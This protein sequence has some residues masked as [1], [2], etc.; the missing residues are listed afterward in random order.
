MDTT[1]LKVP[2][3]ISVITEEDIRTSNA[4][5]ITDVL[6]TSTGLI[7]RDE[8]GNGKS[9][10]VDMRGF[11]ESSK[12]NHLV[13][14]D[15]RRINNIDLSATDWTQIPLD[16]VEKIEIARGA[17]SV[18]YGD[19][20]VAGV[21]NIITK[22]GEG[23]VKV[24]VSS[25]YGSYDKRL[26]KG[27]VS[28]S[29][30]KLSYSFN[31]SYS[32]SS[33]YRENNELETLDFA[34]RLHYDLD[35]FA[36][37]NVSGG[38]H[39]DSYGMPG[40]LLISDFATRTRRDSKYPT[41]GAD[42]KDY[43]IKT[44]S[45]VKLKIFGYDLGELFTD[46]SLRQRESD[47]ITFNDQYETDSDTTISTF[48][49]R[50]VL[51]VEFWDNFENDLV[52]GADYFS[53]DH[54]I[55]SGMVTSEKDD[56]EITKKTL[57]FYGLDEF[58]LFE[59]F[60]LQLGYRYEWIKYRFYQKHGS[61]GTVHND[62]IR[63]MQEGVF[64]SGVSY[65]LTDQ[66]NIY[67]TYAQS[68]RLPN[69]DEFYASLPWGTGL[70][71]ELQPQEADHFEA[72]FK[73]YLKDILYLG[74]NFFYMDVKKEIYW[75]PYTWTNSNYDKTEHAG[76]E[77][78][79]K[80]NPIKGLKLFTNYTYTRPKFKSGSFDSNDIPLVPRH[81]LGIGGNYEII[82]GL[83]VS[84][85]SKF[86]GNRYKM[87][88]QNNTFPKA[89]PYSVTD[90]KLDYKF[91]DFSVTCGINNLFN[92]KYAE[93]EGVSS[94]QEYLYPSPERNFFIGASFEH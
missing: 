76:L 30:D 52:L 93:T 38:Y 19:N 42:I 91:K 21:I 70:N 57:G 13:L 83:I 46:S 64:T 48:N 40:A 26:F 33:G 79:A 41:D 92:E 56:I 89:K 68:Y 31:S 44:G 49:P 71:T 2:G 81:I 36:G 59:L 82:D 24:N 3:A 20:A 8:L 29:F 10:A 78:E 37:F 5:T 23:P 66:T 54:D 69:T 14:V 67:G 47:S 45:N 94:S 73:H 27:E 43:Y 6:R 72:G 53:A 28:G 85:V 63:K 74:G 87:S 15:G 84:S 25:L 22:R 51:N 80:A 32:D 16:Q 4:Q 88:D 61:T 9:V 86:V 18:M 7:I 62:Q 17:S 55:H 39:E 50:Y 90:V 34:T 65:Y 12:M 60:A 35:D 77:L 58:T 75:D 1:S 11:G